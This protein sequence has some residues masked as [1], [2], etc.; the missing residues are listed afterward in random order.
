MAEEA[1]ETPQETTEQPQEEKEIDEQIAVFEP[2]PLAVERK[3]KHPLTGLEKTFVQHEM[4]FLT[5]LKFFRLLSGTLRLAAD[6]ETGGVAQVLQDTFGDISGLVA[7][8]LSEEQAQAI[9]SNQF[10]S[11][12]MKL[13][14]L[15]PDF[16]EETYV[17]ALGAKPEDH[18]WVIEA[19]ENVDDEEGVAILEVFIAQNGKA[20]RRFFD[21]HLRRI[22]GRAQQELELTGGGTEQE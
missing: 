19:I 13:V 8:G 12:V 3:L 18:D 4:G 2:V 11:T 17:F 16:I 20:I 22:A 15:V 5:K 9:A 6:S 21:K 10:L 14:E 1:T 7:Q